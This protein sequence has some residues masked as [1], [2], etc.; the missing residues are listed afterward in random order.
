MKLSSLPTVFLSSTLAALAAPAPYGP[1]SIYLDLT[2]VSVAPRS[3]KAAP[4]A[5]PEAYAP[6]SMYLDMNPSP[7]WQKTQAKRGRK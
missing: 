4:E 5:A 7:I 1:K 6:D 2:P 3:A